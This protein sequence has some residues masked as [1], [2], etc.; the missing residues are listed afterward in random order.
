MVVAG[1]VLLRRLS[2]TSGGKRER[3]SVCCEG[4]GRVE[5]VWRGPRIAVACETLP[6]MSGL[7][8]PLSLV[9]RV[10]YYHIWVPIWLYGWR[11]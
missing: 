3:L 2:W 8:K 7:G 9:K 10:P 6:E 5:E 11:G 1:R 4:R